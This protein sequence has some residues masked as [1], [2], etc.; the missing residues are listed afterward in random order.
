MVKGQESVLI[1][2]SNAKKLASFYE[3]RVGLKRTFEA[4]MGE[5]GEHL[6]GFDA[7]GRSCIYIID[8][9]KVKGKNKNPERFILNL[10]VDTI[11]KE[12]KKLLKNKV[13]L[14]QKIYHVEDYGKIATFEDPEGNYFQLVQVKA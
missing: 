10:E 11:E 6:Y 13:K 5:K 3:K 2:S 1:G 8:H 7:K 12:V 14:I 9:S 4:E